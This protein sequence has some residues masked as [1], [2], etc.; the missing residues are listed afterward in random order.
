MNRICHI[1][2]NDFK[3]SLMKANSVVSSYFENTNQNEPLKYLECERT[4]SYN[5]II[6]F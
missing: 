1:R 2:D 4:G 6:R 3:P 5:E